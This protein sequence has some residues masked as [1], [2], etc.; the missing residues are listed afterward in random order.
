[1]QLDMGLK[2]Y[3]EVPK[4]QLAAEKSKVRKPESRCGRVAALISELT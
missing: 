2:K 3:F 1:L 4:W